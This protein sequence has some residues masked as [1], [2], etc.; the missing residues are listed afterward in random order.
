M[1]GGQPKICQGFDGFPNEAVMPR[2]SVCLEEEWREMPFFPGQIFKQERSV[3]GLLLHLKYFHIAGTSG[4]VTKPARIQKKYKG[5]YIHGNNNKPQ[6][7]HH[8]GTASRLHQ[9]H[10]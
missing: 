8:D 5:Q 10:A 3:T 1:I 9:Q 6:I 4:R 2:G 7:G